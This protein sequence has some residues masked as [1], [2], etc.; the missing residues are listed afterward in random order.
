MSSL[1]CTDNSM[2]TINEITHHINPK[3]FSTNWTQQN[4]DPPHCMQNSLLLT[5]DVQVY[6]Q[7]PLNNANISEETKLALHKLLKNFN[8]IISK[9]DNDKGQIDLIEMHITTRLKSAPVAA[10]PYPL[11]PKHHDFLKQEIKKIIRCRN[12][13]QKHVPM[14]KPYCSCQKPHL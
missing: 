8:S 1:S 11:A 14:G 9:S 10:Q 7:V 6:R 3:T 2:H 12:Y 5:S 13:L 4:S